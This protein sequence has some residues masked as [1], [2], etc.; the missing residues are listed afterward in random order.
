[1]TDPLYEK[2]GDPRGAGAH[3]GTLF[4]HAAENGPARLALIHDEDGSWSVS[5][6]FGAE[7]PDSTMA[8]G[9]AYG[10]GSTL[11]VALSQAVGELAP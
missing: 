11:E 3:I 10:T 6:E 5:Y 4:E 8:G 7:A 1:M 9:A 2:L